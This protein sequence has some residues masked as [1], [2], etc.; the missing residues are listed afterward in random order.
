[1]ETSIVLAGVRHEPEAPYVD[2]LIELERAGKIDI[3]V[4]SGFDADQVRASDEQRRRNIEY[5]SQL[6]TLVKSPGPLRLDFPHFLDS[7]NVFG[8]DEAAE[9]DEQIADIV[10]GVGRRKRAPSSGC[11]MFTT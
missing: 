8:S 10:L 1:M 11:T 5:L 7:N 2:R 9:W 3:F 6:R 4:T